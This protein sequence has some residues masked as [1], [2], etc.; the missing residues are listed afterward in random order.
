MTFKP[1]SEILFIELVL[2][3]YEE[4]K[5]STIDIALFIFCIVPLVIPM[6]ILLCVFFIFVSVILPLVAHFHVSEC[7]IKILKSLIFNCNGQQFH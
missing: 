7:N 2:H 1:H 6:F 4:K 5:V 3:S